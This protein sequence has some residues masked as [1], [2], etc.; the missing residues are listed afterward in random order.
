MLGSGIVVQLGMII[1]RSNSPYKTFLIC[2]NT[3]TVSNELHS[4]ED[5]IGLFYV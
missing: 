4:A 3:L 2:T 1:I 5:D